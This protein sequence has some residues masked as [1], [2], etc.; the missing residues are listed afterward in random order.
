M[1]PSPEIA[2]SDPPITDRSGRR[3][4]L[5]TA[6]FAG[7]GA[8]YFGGTHLYLQDDRWTANR[9]FWVSR[10]RAPV[11]APL[12]GEGSADVAIIGGGVTGLSTAIHLL[13]R[14]PNLRVVLLEA[15]YVGFGA[16]GRSGGVLGDGTEMGTPEGTA[17]NVARVLELVD[18]FRIE[19]DL[20]TDPETQL[21]PYRYAVGL[22]KAAEGLGAFV[23]EGT[24]VREIDRG[25]TVTIRGDGFSLRVK[26]LVVAANGYT[27]RLGI[28]SRRIFPV[29]TGAAVTPP[30]PDE[31]LRTIPDS[32]FVHTSPEMYMWGRKAPGGRVLVGAGAEY[33]YGNGLHHNGERPLFA[34]L[35]RLMAKTY[36]ALASS[37]FEHAWT[38]PMGATSDQEPILGR[39][40]TQG[41]IIYGGAYSGHGIAMGTKT[42]SFLA[43]MIEDAAPPAWMLRRTI[44]LPG[45][46]LRYIGVNTVI[47]MMNLG[48]F[49]MPKHD[50]SKA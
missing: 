49:H 35:H 14:S 39:E 29:H 5:K 40:G 36:P 22:K 21:D 32:I 7:A 19:C 13:M 18:R 9:S 10:G 33:F 48:L 31:V 37:P 23:H 11:N 43:G 27:P 26:R 34:A 2:P 20:E 8:V 24:R 16:T 12:R 28:A 15:E 47:N 38:G 42:G 41:N 44:D 17:D 50:H 46:P 25:P 3:A 45:E 4:F 1:P 6:A 30:L